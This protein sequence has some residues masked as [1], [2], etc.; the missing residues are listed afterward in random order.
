M[1][2]SKSLLASM[3]SELEHAGIAYALLRDDVPHAGSDDLDILVWPEDRGPFI[4]L[5][6]RLGFVMERKRIAKKDVFW[7]WDSGKLL[8]L[9]VHYALIQGGLVY[10]ELPSRNSVIGR[11]PPRLSRQDELSHLVFHE[12]LGK[13]GITP[14]RIAR[15]EELRQSGVADPVAT[16]IPDDRVLSEI[17]SV[18]A[19]PGS[20][21]PGS[22]R[23]NNAAARIRRVLLRSPANRWYRTKNRLL[24]RFRKPRG[25]LV[26]FLGVD[27]SGKS[28]TMG[29]VTESL[30][31]TGRT[32]VATTYLGPWGN[33]RTRVLN[34]AYRWGLTPP[35]EDWLKLAIERL[36]GDRSSPPLL[37][38]LVKW[39][40]GRIRG[41]GY[42]GA[43]YFDVWYRYLQ[44]V[45][46]AIARGKVVLADR[47]IYDLR[48][49]DRNRPTSQF[50]FV[51][52]FVTWLFPRPHL[53]ILL[54][55]SPER[56]TARSSQ[57]TSV[58]IT[59]LQTVYRRTL[60]GLPVIEVSSDESASKVADTITGHIVRAYFHRR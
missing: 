17:R 41:W 16:R 1:T 7:R 44:D 29:I 22:S 60:A 47:Y 26:A 54:Y 46:P 53:I 45:R 56:I 57:L 12:L 9:D 14:K 20:Y 52:K 58:Q 49:L 24:R 31:Q 51:R 30:Q 28:T 6:V 2:E 32:R 39:L 38:C 21:T 8:V 5:V 37:E 55:A 15:I 33:F 48:Y 10:Q 18:I 40:K 42:Y 27:G 4:E 11:A 35:K 36:R 23:A 19:E 13:G 50:P 43:V 25:V 34:S 3:F 59:S